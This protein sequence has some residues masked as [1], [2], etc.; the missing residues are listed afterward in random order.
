MSPG[1]AAEGFRLAVP[2][3]VRTVQVAYDDQAGRPVPLREDLKQAVR[4]F[5]GRAL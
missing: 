1:Q 3:E 4:R 2:I 5:E